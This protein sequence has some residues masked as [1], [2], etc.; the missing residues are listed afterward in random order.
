[1]L[2]HPLLCKKYIKS[3]V[4]FNAWFNKWEVQFGKLHIAKLNVLFVLYIIPKQHCVINW[5]VGLGI[6][7]NLPIFFHRFQKNV[8]FFQLNAKFSLKYFYWA[9]IGIS[10]VIN[11]L[12]KCILC[13][14]RFS[15]LNVEELSPPTLGCVTALGVGECLQSPIV[16][17]LV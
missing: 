3:L 4:G 15:V 5:Q 16:M 9:S 10:G 11:L 7:K 17:F 8:Y 6:Y 1:M 2:L 13:F 14:I 12:A